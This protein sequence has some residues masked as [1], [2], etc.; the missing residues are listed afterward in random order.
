MVRLIFFFFYFRSDS[1][2]RLDI[3]P[4][5]SSEQNMLVVTNNY[6]HS[7]KL[8]HFGASRASVEIVSVV[9]FGCGQR[10]QERDE[11]VR[12]SRCGGVGE[13]CAIQ[14]TITPKRIEKNFYNRYPVK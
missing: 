1:N 8:G 7:P 14:K 6:L 9:P 4:R 3:Q 10:H 5:F 11:N 12:R 13:Q 2:S